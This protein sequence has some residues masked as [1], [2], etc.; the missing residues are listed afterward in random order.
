MSKELSGTIFFE[1]DS[2]RWGETGD[3]RNAMGVWTGDRAAVE[4][5]NVY[6][7]FGIPYFGI[8]APM[9]ARVGLQ[10]FGARPNM[11]LTVDGMGITLGTKIDPATVSLQWAKAIEGKDASSDDVDMYGLHVNTKMG[12]LTLGGYAFTFNMNTYPLNNAQTVYGGNPTNQADF[13]WFG[14]Y[15]DGKIGPFLTN[16]DF[17]LDTG[18]VEKK[19]GTPA[20]DVDYDGWA[21]RLKINY[22]YEKFN[23]G[24]TFMYAS[25]AD[26]KKTSRQGL[27]GQSVVNDPAGAGLTTRKVKS[28]VIPPGSEEFVAFGES[29]AFYGQWA[30]PSFGQL[31]SWPPASTGANFV[32]RGSIGGT[33]F[34][35]AFAGYKATPWYKITMEALYIGDTTKNGNTVGD[36]VKATGATRDDS[37]IGWEI[38]LINEINIYKN[39][40]WNI[41]G[42]ILFAG[43]A[44]D[45][46]VA[47]YTAPIVTTDRNKSPKNPW[48]ISTMLR[49]EF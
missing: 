12:N 26:L 3:G 20:K 11:F 13:W 28:Y 49:Y 35:K 27:P 37:T 6:I 17:V 47:S 1:M 38:D 43:D 4:I 8:P 16:F 21:T 15:V 48:A 24:G 2:N 34:L 25:G 7:D 44:L 9:T 5:K 39:L 40:K 41:A 45:Q 22:P 30:I 14:A 33:W 46:R 29:M 36:A 23:F 32:T 18:E 19:H 10:P 31:G 42:G